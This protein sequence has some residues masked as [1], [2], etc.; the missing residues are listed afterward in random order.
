MTGLEPNESR[1]TSKREVAILLGIA[2]L[3]SSMVAL[4]VSAQKGSFSFEIELRSS[5]AGTAQ[6]FYD[7]GRGMN[8]ADSVRTPVRAGE[9][10]TTLEFALPAGE[11]HAL[12]FDP[13]EYGN[14]RVAIRNPRI[15]DIS[16]Q[17]L[18]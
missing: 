14:C 7:I 1:P 6:L 18:R 15:V 4:F 17:V 2:A 13:V 8:D 16:G 9:S 12:R 10:V 3:A 5:Q 11:Y